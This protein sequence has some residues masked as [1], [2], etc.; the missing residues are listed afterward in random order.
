VVFSFRGIDQ[1]DGSTM[2]RLTKGYD[3]E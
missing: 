3:T 1:A 2:V